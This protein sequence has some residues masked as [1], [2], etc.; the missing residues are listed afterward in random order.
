MTSSTGSSGLIFV[1]S[2]PIRHGVA[3]RRQVDDRGDAGEVL[4]QHAAGRK[5]ISSTGS[6]LGSQPARALMS[7]AVTI[8]RLLPQEVFQQHLERIGQPAT[9]SVGEGS[10]RKIS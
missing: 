10:S 2:P 6:A 3:H 9:S 1:G 5:A 8:C 7:S 4:E